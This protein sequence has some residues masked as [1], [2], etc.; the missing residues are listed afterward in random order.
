MIKCL[1]V[2][3][4]STARKMRRAKKTSGGGTKL[5]DRWRGHVGDNPED[6]QTDDGTRTTG[7]ES[8]EETGSVP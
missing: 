7:V 5:K 4:S 6:E 3:Y 2:D 8:P 1:M